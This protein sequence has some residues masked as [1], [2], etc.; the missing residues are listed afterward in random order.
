MTDLHFAVWDDDLEGL[1]RLLLQPGAKDM[2]ESRDRNGYTPLLLAYRMGRTRCANSLLAAGADAKSRTPEG[3][4]SIQVAALTA[5]PDLVRS[6]VVAFLAETDAAFQRRLPN[7]QE[8][9]HSMPD[10]SLTMKWE[11]SSWV[12]MLSRLLP[13][14]TYTIWKRG[15]SLRL[16]TTLLGM[17]GLT[18]ERGQVSLILLGSEFGERAGAMTVVDWI[19]KAAADARKSFSEPR[20]IHQQ[21][22]VRKLLVQKQKITDFWARDM[23]L[24]PVMQQGLIRGLFS[25]VSKVVVGD[26]TPR[27]RIS[28]GASAS[29]GSS[30]SDTPFSPS[31]MASPTPVATPAATPASPAVVHVDDPRQAVEDVGAWSN[32]VKYEML[33]LCVRDVSYEQI[34]TDLKVTDWWRPEYSL[35]MGSGES[36]GE[37]SPAATPSTPAAS[38]AVAQAE[39]PEKLLTPL[40]KAM[41]AIKLGKINER[42]AASATLEQLEGMGLED[43][44]GDGSGGGAGGAGAEG[45]AAEGGAGS[46]AE[47]SS[48]ASSMR[49]SL[50]ALAG[51]GAH[52]AA[53]M[54]FEDYFGFDRPAASSSS[55]AAADSGKAYTPYVHKDG[56]L[57]KPSGT[58]C[59]F[60]PAYTTEEDKILD[61]QVAFSRDFP[62]TVEQF[63]PVAEVMA[64]TGKHA[65]NMRRFFNTKM[66]V[67]AGFPVKFSI[68]VF[69]T[70]TATITFEFCEAHPSRRP[71]KGR[72]ELPADIKMGAYV[73][74]G[75]IRQL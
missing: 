48:A 44:D 56:K 32:C 64:R 12:P 28:E 63:L 66:P 9:L 16:D 49:R 22:W 11:F 47:D 34:L 65:E 54:S 75:F 19:D 71:P 24:T 29:G 58:V 72:F 38:S 18:W 30:G 50:A 6:S 36:G 70:I 10:F 13:S 57:H 39:A 37:S 14:D 68:P 59:A 2:L 27:G 21:D 42:N 53:M 41:K 7:L 3:W 26:K 20:D 1:Q 5:N 52:S 61:L 35:E 69:P 15:S 46:H 74:R 8:R 25:K 55:A 51:P 31:A 45:E 17:T 40:R 33:N 4:E 67:G 43:G 73:E 62:L 60:Q 23:V